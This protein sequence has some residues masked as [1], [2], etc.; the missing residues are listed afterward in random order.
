MAETKPSQAGL[1]YTYANAGISAVSSIA[2]AVVNTQ[3]FKAQVEAQ[4]DA[5]I[6]NMHNV[7]DTYE[8]TQYKLAEDIQRLDS[9]FSDKVSERALEGM[10]N[11]ARAKA[12]S[13]ET[14][15]SGGSTS[16]A[17]AQVKTDELFDVGVINAQ[18]NS[19]LT[20]I[21]AQKET[22]KMNAVNQLKTL[23]SGGLNYK[24]NMFVS[25]LGGASNALGNL[26]ATMPKDVA[27]DVFNFNTSGVNPD[28][29]QSKPKGN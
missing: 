29:M 18:R 8:Y 7:M 3:A 17:I 27:V 23:A 11:I 25:A 22:S 10:K 2:S 1:N 20:S 15:T 6:A 21:L 26:L 24:A 19:T 12:A 16:E 28:V 5:K 9:A 13:A 4:T 14:G